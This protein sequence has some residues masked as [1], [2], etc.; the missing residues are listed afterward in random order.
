MIIIENKAIYILSVEA[1][2]IYASERQKTEGGYGI[3]DKTGNISVRKFINVLD[4]SLDS[5]KLREVYE[6]KR[7]RKDFSFSIN[8][9]EYTK[10]IINV[11][12]KYSYKLFNKVAKNIYVRDGYKYR[13]CVFENCVCIKDGKL[14]AIQTDIDL[15]DDIS[16]LPVEMLEDCFSFEDNH[17]IQKGTI[18][19]LMTKA[20]LRKHLYNNGFNCDGLHY[21]RYKRSSGS[22]R[23]GKC[24]F[25]YDLLA[26]A[27][28]KW[29]KCGL[30]V[31]K[32]DKIDL[33]AYE[34]Y[35]SL[36]MSSIIDTIEILP[37]NIL[38]IDD[39]DSIFEDDVI[40]VESKDNR[41][42][43]SQKKATIINSIWDGQSL[44]DISL[45]VKYADK[46]MLL[47]RNRFF[48]TCAFNTNIQQ[49][50]RDNNITDISQ[51]HGKTLATDISQIKFITT[52][53]SV[54]YLKFGTLEDWLN[55]ID[56]TFG[57]VKYEKETHFF[58]G[59][60]VQTHYQL[61][62]TL[63]FTYEDMEKF[64]YQSLD[65]INYVRNDPDI[66]RY[67][68]KY[69]YEEMEITPLNSKNEIIFKLLG[70]NNKF[71][72]TKLYYDFRN[73]LIKA[74]IDKLKDGRVLING[75][76]STLFGN[77]L[78]MLKAS[79]GLFDGTSEL[80]DNEVH[81]K[82]FDYG[83]TLLGSRSPH[84]TMGDVALFKNKRSEL[85]D[86]YFNLS[87]EII[88]I[89]SINN[90]I[91]QRLQG[92]DFDSDS[93]LLTDNQQL[94]D[95]ARK[96]YDMFKVPT[97][98][99][100]AKKTQRY[101]TTEHQC[102]LDIRTSVNK[103]GEIINLS[104]QLNSL[105]WD[106]VNRGQ[107]IEDQ[108][109][110]YCD[111]CKLSALSGIEIDKAKKEFAIDSTKEIKWLKE[112]YKIVSNGKTVKPMFFKRITLGN[113]YEL[114][115]RVKYKYFKTSMDYLQQKINKYNFR[116]NRKSKENF[117]P[118]IDIVKEPDLN[119]FTQGYYYEQKN[120]IID[121]I[122]NT[123]QSIS[124]IYTGYETMSTDEKEQ[125]R[126][127]ATEM[128]QECV[129]YINDISTSKATM[130]LLLKDMEKDKPLSRFIFEILFGA[131]NTSFFE[132]IIDSKE[133]LSRLREWKHGNI[134]LYDYLFYKEKVS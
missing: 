40:A 78:E 104:Q 22:S 16:P 46:G 86:R 115:D 105:L 62:N 117:I 121:I 48:K 44:M 70:I 53:N 19:V 20:E 17:Y 81:S 127:I 67:H 99:V 66:L 27:M 94:I 88:C 119:T 13:D 26:P 126:R 110:L 71:A 87:K 58:D 24:L 64:L 102:D 101:Y 79:V 98:L 47:L 89:N 120:R 123:K 130:Y 10:M 42:V 72:K 83:I 54:K 82:R 6:K 108:M 12:F 125:V 90:N 114:S 132:M 109:E 29:D 65:Y 107:A 118:F 128:K 59:R 92:S 63:Q 25:V 28:Q 35:I 97:C 56:V 9:K 80:Q 55:N 133:D 4:Y 39:Y 15:N 106:N 91:L 85:Y 111:I 11:K 31:N 2:D 14:V 112:K 95:L 61:L 38:V 124:S 93:L 77:G 23:V 68:I 84:V 1:K 96:N 30:K 69:P 37:Q 8:N 52:P 51:L 33:A 7:R 73:D 134:P 74:M 41:L 60:M 5:I 76:Y 122:K 57:V 50:F 36:P 100:S 131:P 113:G 34:A 45:F 103:I 43:S 21:V 129:E 75:N 18:P 116:Q 49:F 32:G 3:R